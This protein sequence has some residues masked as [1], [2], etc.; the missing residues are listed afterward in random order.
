MGVPTLVIGWSHKYAE[1]AAPLQGE[2][3]ALSW[4]NF[5]A[6]NAMAA[7]QKL[8]GHSSQVRAMIQNA[9]PSIRSGAADNFVLFSS[10]YN[11]MPQKMRAA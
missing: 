3:Y 7:Y 5:S 11:I 8:D 6:D 1:M 9:L 2:D 10:I 4:K